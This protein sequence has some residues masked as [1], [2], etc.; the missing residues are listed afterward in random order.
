MSDLYAILAA[1]MR[2]EHDGFRRRRALPHILARDDMQ[3]LWKWVQA[4]A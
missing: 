3:D 4:N 2:Q 1:W